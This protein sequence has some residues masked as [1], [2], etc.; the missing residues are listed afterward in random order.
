[1]RHNLHL[2][3]VFVAALAVLAFA[4]DCYADIVQFRVDGE[5][6][7]TGLGYAAGQD[8]SFYF[9]L[10]DYRPETLRISPDPPYAQSACCAGQFAWRQDLPTEAHLWSDV[11]GTGITG[12][13]NPIITTSHNTTSG[14][15]LWLG[16]SP[17]QTLDLQSFEYAGTDSNTGL[18]ANGYRVTGFQAQAAYLGLDALAVYGDTLFGSPV[19]DPTDLFAGLYGTYPRDPIFSAH[20]RINVL[21]PHGADRFDFRIDSLTISPVPAPAAAWLFG[22][23]LLALGLR[24][25]AA[26]RRAG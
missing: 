13:W 18:F 22:S 23:G 4:K 21:G 6:I 15:A 5:I 17:S 19:P 9:V 1:M 2:R 16:H 7:A 8:V 20:G 10:R 12:S 24:M 14:L 26:G 25:R 3:S 11:F